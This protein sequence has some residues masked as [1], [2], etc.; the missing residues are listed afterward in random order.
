MYLFM[1]VI[2]YI[3]N[4]PAI[5]KVIE[6]LLEMPYSLG[7]FSCLQAYSLIGIKKQLTC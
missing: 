1:V 3:I 2:N 4:T 6:L 5:N 7:Q